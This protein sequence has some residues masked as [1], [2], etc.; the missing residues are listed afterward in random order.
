MNPVKPIEELLKERFALAIGLA[1]G[2]ENV[3]DP[4]IKPADPKFADY[5]CN[6]A[7]ALAKRVGKKPHEVAS[8]ILKHLKIDDLAE[9]PTVA[10]PGFINLKLRPDWISRT[11]IAAFSGPQAA[12]AGVEKAQDAQTIV[13][14]YSGPN[15][16][17]Q[18]HVG[19]LRSTIIG[20]TIA[21]V[22]AFLGHQVVRQNHI[23]DFGTQ[24]GML[25]HYL[26]SHGLA[27]IP[28]AIQDLDRY[29]KEATANFKTDPAFRETAR[30]TV[31][32]LQSGG[33][34]A[35]ALWNRMR[36]ETH[37]HYTEIYRLLGVTLTDADERG[38]SF[39][40]SRLAP[41]VQRVQDTLPVG[42][43]SFTGL[44][45]ELGK[46]A[47][48]LVDQSLPE[49]E[50]E[51]AEAALA[52]P[53]GKERIEEAK[54]TWAVQKPFATLS[55]GAVCVFLPKWVGRDK[56]PVPLMLQKRDGGFPYSAT[57]MA[58]LYFRV[59]ENKTAPAD[60]KPLAHDWHAHRVIYFTDV[61]Q[62]QHFAMVFDAFRACQWDLHPATKAKLSLE[63]APFGTML[64]EDKR[65]FK[66]REGTA[67]A[68]KLL[69]E[70][71]V[72]RAGKVDAARGAELSPE[73]RKKVDV[74]VGIGAVKYFDLKQDRATDY[75]FSFDRMLSLEGNTGPYLQMAYT[76]VRSIYRKGNLTPE[77]VWQSGAAL[78]LQ[79]ADELALAKKLLAFGGVVE[80][81]ARDLKPHYLCTYLYELSGAF[82]RF[83]ENCPVLKA[84]TDAL[85]NSRLLLCDMVARVLRLGL[86]ELLG[87]EVLDEM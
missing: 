14:D 62:S 31:V 8:D 42:G 63:H 38:E 30:Q 21:R 24:F 86:Q 12:R 82:A 61:R 56:N 67:A 55:G 85:R 68:L 57:D 76:R 54:A 69:L 45:P 35:V 77:Q 32:E 5:Q 40:R 47:S 71:A 72:E 75:V 19:H 70:E 15:V 49:T 81:V 27:D 28:L 52:S 11:L 9:P 29:Y 64:G 87:I 34:A 44:A 33:A 43:E 36:V 23:G 80:S 6:V 84:E 2:A 13:V 1:F 4:P 41:L 10:G 20:D 3:I 46:A 78:I 17:K 83:F 66:T 39:Y 58:A 59:Q 60:Q 25:I 37:R 26:R 74:A 53:N 73:Q 22:L 65:P 16:A 50:E 51:E 18:M 48:A 79:H 7:M